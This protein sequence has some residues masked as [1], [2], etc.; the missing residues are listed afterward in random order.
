[1]AI[2]RQRSRR[3]QP[4]RKKM[5]DKKVAHSNRADAVALRKNASSLAKVDR[6]SHGTRLTRQRLTVPFRFP[7]MPGGMP[8]AAIIIP[9]RDDPI[10][11]ERCL[12]ALSPRP[13]SRFASSTTDRPS[14]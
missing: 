6:T 12:N 4:D 8:R 2:A 3:S 9:H 1:M 7:P 5:R 14:I 10:R 13:M 11:L